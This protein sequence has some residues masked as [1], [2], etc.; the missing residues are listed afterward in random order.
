M[1]ALKANHDIQPLFTSLLESMSAMYYMTNYVTKTGPSTTNMLSLMASAASNAQEDFATLDPV[2]R[3]RR[4]I[5]RCYN[6]ASNTVEFSAA[7]I[8]S[9]AL[10]LGKQGTHLT[11]NTFTPL[12]TKQYYD[13]ICGNS[14]EKDEDDFVSVP[15]DCLNS[16]DEQSDEVTAGNARIDDFRFRPTELSEMCLY[17]H[18]MFMYNRSDMHIASA[19]ME[20]PPFD[21][22]NRSSNNSVRYQYMYGHP[23][24]ESDSSSMRLSPLV[25]QLFGPSIPHSD[26]DDQ[27]TYCSRI[28]CLFKPWRT[29]LCLLGDAPNWTTAFQR[30]KE[31]ALIP[32]RIQQ[33]IENLDALVK[34]K[35]DRDRDIKDRYELEPSNSVTADSL[36]FGDCATSSIDDEETFVEE[37]TLLKDLFMDPIDSYTEDALSFGVDRGLFTYEDPIQQQEMKHCIMQA[38]DHFPKLG[39]SHKQITSHWRVE[40]KEQLKQKKLSA[41]QDN[42]ETGPVHPQIHS[43]LEHFPYIQLEEDFAVNHHH[44]QTL[45]DHFKLNEEQSKFFRNGLE[46][47]LAVESSVRFGTP[48]PKQLLMTVLGPGGTGKSYIIA[49]LLKS[50]EIYSLRHR[51][52][53]AAYTGTAANNIGGST[54]HSLLG[55]T[56]MESEQTASHTEGLRRSKSKKDWKDVT[57]LIIDEISM[58]G[59]RFFHEISGMLGVAKEMTDGDSIFGGIGLILT[60]DFLQLEPIMDASLMTPSAVEKGLLSESK[61][62]DLCDTT[63]HGTTGSDAG[64]LLNS[65]LNTETKRKNAWAQ[66]HGRMLWKS[67][68]TVIFL[69]RLVRQQSDPVFGDLLGR[70]REG[71]L[72]TDD[73]A[74]LNHCVFKNISCPSWRDAPFV[75]LRN[76][77]RQQLNNKA[78]MR[79]AADRRVP[80]YAIVASDK[81]AGV[82]PSFFKEERLLCTE[83]KTGGICGLLYLCE[84]APVSFT[85]NQYVELG[86]TNGACAKVSSICLSTVDVAQASSAFAAMPHRPIILKELP[87]YII[88]D[89]RQPDSEVKHAPLANLKALEVPIFPSKAPVTLRKTMDGTKMQKSFTRT[90]FALCLGFAFTDY[91]VQGKSLDKMIADLVKPPRHSNSIHSLYVILSRVRTLAGLAV[92]R[93]FAQ[94]DIQAQLSAKYT[95][96]MTRL[97]S[98]CDK[99][100]I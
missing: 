12:Y 93:P 4:L 42:E 80:L 33:Y 16:Y 19:S 1:L 10:G 72:T 47:V 87:E 31:S 6:V 40:L 56:G 81:I 22:K 95:N 24:R 91:K 9:M 26:T 37:R 98:I 73:Y 66:H 32:L 23:R 50:L 94:A 59:A 36:M 71:K 14:K 88:L 74:L 60:G 100:Y 77:L 68:D 57:L 29:Q 13:W 48:Y 5:H 51:V 54:I 17:E 53:V 38:T 90:G 84:G 41:S 39:D 7:H 46:Y 8:A 15:L 21:P 30:W 63:L 49:A 27:E 97:K 62:R 85:K 99:K 78:V 18:S 34:S 83:E 89:V 35:E 92:L 70:L 45:S 76:R 44:V 61:L 43:S 11:S 96:E 65:E 67:I 55:I 2:N 64:T 58:V 79:F 82:L 25:P 28:L 52:V 75:V 86:I 69:H 20:D 3:T